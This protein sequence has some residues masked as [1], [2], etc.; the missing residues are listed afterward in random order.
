MTEGKSPG[1][2]VVLADS[3]LS[4]SFTVMGCFT[5]F[6]AGGSTSAGGINNTGQIVGSAL[7]DFQ[8]NGYLY[9][10]G[11]ATPIN[12]PSVD[13]GY[14][15]T[16]LG[17]INDEGQTV[18]TYYIAGV[19]HGFLYSNGVF[20]EFDDPLGADGAWTWVTGI[21][22]TGQIVGYYSSADGLFGFLANPTTA[23]PEPSALPIVFTAF[24]GIVGFRMRKRSG[25]RKAI[26][27]V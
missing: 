16:S 19:P 22:D 1:S 3:P 12:Y 26:R 24:L 4:V 7:I 11:T 20:T 25:D 5:D 8:P 13:P 21:N 2:T 14:S 18:G 15:G 6:S 27:I 10:G 9:S 17:G 23:T